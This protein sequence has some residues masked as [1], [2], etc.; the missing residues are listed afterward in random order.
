MKTAKK[1]GGKMAR[2]F[3]YVCLGILALV[4]AFQ[5]GGMRASAESKPI[6]MGMI[7]SREPTETV[8][9]GPC[10]YVVTDSGD[11]YYK[12]VYTDPTQAPPQWQYFGNVFDA[13]R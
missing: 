2:R 4:V 7:E 12:V 10:I 6:P 3:M 1:E 5:L 8:T 9:R 13:Q 11:C